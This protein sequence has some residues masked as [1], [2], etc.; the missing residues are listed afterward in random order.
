[1]VGFDHHAWAAPPP[2]A[3]RQAEDAIAG[4]ILFR[5]AGTGRATIVIRRHFR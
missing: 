4:Q 3:A 2:G 1:M 5:P